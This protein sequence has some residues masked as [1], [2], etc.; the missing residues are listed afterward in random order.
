[1][2][3]DDWSL[4]TMISSRPSC[5]A[6]D[7]TQRAIVASSFRAGMMAET[8]VFRVRGRRR[9]G[10]SPLG[11]DEDSALTSRAGLAGGTDRHSIIGARAGPPKEKSRGRWFAGIACEM[12]RMAARP[13]VAGRY[14]CEYP[15]RAVA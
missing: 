7:S 10:D 3:S 11:P 12:L 14:A 4:T 2:E 8:M 13:H 15:R 6:S 5:G 9:P 1:M